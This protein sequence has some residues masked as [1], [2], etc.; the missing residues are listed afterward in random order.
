M[1]REKG[2]KGD[3]PSLLKLPFC[4][5]LFNCTF[6][7]FTNFHALIFQTACEMRSRWCDVASAVSANKTTVYYIQPWW[8]GVFICQL[9]H[10]VD[11][12]AGHSMGLNLQVW[13]INRSETEI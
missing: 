12:C 11:C 1:S 6:V 13:C 2:D 3:N 9:S 4:S 10:S 7:H 5:G 8:L